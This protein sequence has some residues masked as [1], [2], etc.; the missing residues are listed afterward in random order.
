MGWSETVRWNGWLTAGCQLPAWL[1]ILLLFPKLP[2]LPV[3][4]CL[5][6]ACRLPP[7]II[8]VFRFSS[9]LSSG[10]RLRDSEFSFPPSFL[11]SSF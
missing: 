11:F 9:R 10:P 5:K 6:V 2:A 3:S 8:V 4:P 7:T 1:A